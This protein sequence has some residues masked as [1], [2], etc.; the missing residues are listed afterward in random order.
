MSSPSGTRNR[1]GA[2]AYGS[3]GPCGANA[4]ALRS[5]SDTTKKHPEMTRRVPDV[6][7]QYSPFGNV[8]SFVD[9]IFCESASKACKSLSHGVYQ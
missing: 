4:I 1:S 6:R 2:N 7:D 9:V 5:S 8:E 3:Y